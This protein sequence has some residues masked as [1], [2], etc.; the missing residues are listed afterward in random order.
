MVQL[1]ERNC[2][3]PKAESEVIEFSF[4]DVSCPRD[5]LARSCSRVI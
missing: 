5:E 2:I 4:T 3:Y 1:L